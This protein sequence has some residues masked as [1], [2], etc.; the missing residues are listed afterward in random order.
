MKKSILREREQS[1]LYDADFY[2]WTRSAAEGLRRGQLPDGDVQRIAQEIADM[3]KRDRRELRS[4]MIV[5]IMHLMKWAVQ[6]KLRKKSSWMATIH[7]QRDQIDDLL[8]DSPSLRIPLV[9]DLP[10]LYARAASRAADETGMSIGV[11]MR[12]SAFTGSVAH[13]GRL[14]ADSWLPD[15]IDDLFS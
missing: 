7:E 11:F 1:S 2:L 9:Q 4:R 12:G 10:Q 14:L 3:G 6:P 15:T 13:I 8:A 5:L